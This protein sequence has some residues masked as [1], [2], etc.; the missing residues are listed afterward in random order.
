MI[1]YFFLSHIFLFFVFSTESTD[2]I[3]FT[4]PVLFQKNVY[5]Y[6]PMSAATLNTA[7]SELNGNIII[8]NLCI[9]TTFSENTNTLSIG[10]ANG[11]LPTVIIWNNL[12][13]AQTTDQF[14]YLGMSE[15]GQLCTYKKDVPSDTLQTEAIQLNTLSANNLDTLYFKNPKGNIVIGNKTGNIYFYTN[16]LAINSHISSENQNIT[17]ESDVNVN[18]IL[19]DNLKANIIEINANDISIKA[20]TASFDTITA[21]GD[22]IFGSE[23]APLNSASIVVNNTSNLTFTPIIPGTNLN[24]TAIPLQSISTSENIMVVID[25]YSNVGLLPSSIENATIQEINFCNTFKP[26]NIINTENI[27]VNITDFIWEEKWFAF[28]RTNL[29]NIIPSKLVSLNGKTSM[30]GFQIE[31]NFLDK[32]E[33]A[34]DSTI[35]A[36]INSPIVNIDDLSTVNLPWRVDDNR[37]VNLFIKEMYNAADYPTQIFYQCFLKQTRTGSPYY[38]VCA[39]K[40]PTE[41]NKIRYISDLPLKIFSYKERYISDICQKTKKQKK[42]IGIIGDETY[43]DIL[44]KLINYFF[45]IEKKLLEEN[46]TE[47]ELLQKIEKEI[48]KLKNLKR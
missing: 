13:N 2:T 25:Q 11:S 26:K 42:R 4:Q 14:N 10:N 21:K 23:A 9:N 24:I 40:T 32:I 39:S 5:N 27:T 16:N 45:D 12:P 1:R 20:N 48:E 6:S 18:D 37:F 35:T 36:T 29:L 38:R 28:N 7:N 46:A 30:L 8:N 34:E 47:L 19:A 33:A 44:N 17:F 43:F 41:E 31:N 15:I 3:S 22:I